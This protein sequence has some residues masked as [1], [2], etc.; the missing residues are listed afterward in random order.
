MSA[1][2]LWLG[3]GQKQVYGGLACC[4][5]PFLRL[6]YVGRPFAAL[7]VQRPGLATGQADLLLPFSTQIYRNLSLALPACMLAE[8]DGFSLAHY[9]NEKQGEY[10]CQRIKIFEAH[11]LVL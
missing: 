5:W 10:S 1:V 3:D 11:E 8:W 7:L 4:L 6:P 2:E 9:E